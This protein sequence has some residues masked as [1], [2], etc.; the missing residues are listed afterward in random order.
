[1]Q[2]TLLDVRTG[3]AEALSPPGE[4]AMEASWSPDGRSIAFVR[5]VGQADEVWLMPTP[6]SAAGN[7]V[8]TNVVGGP[9]PN[10][11]TNAGELVAPGSRA[12]AGST[13]AA[14]GATPTAAAGYR[15]V[16]GVNAYPVWSPAGNTIAYLA[17]RRGSFDLF[18]QPLTS[19]LTPNGSPQRLTSGQHLDAASAISWG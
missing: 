13:A 18:I 16:A 19:S 11:R 5:R 8:L 7:A 9:A 14:A 15:L 17:P 2:L 3:H 12:G 6:G 10:G 1:G 4:T